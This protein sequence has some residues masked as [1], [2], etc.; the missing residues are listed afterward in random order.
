MVKAKT[1]LDLLR[2]QLV[3]AQNDLISYSK[4]QG[5]SPVI[6]ANIQHKRAQVAALEA[7][8]KALEEQE[9]KE[10]GVQTSMQI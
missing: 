2:E 9:A 8:I 4:F 7:E 5:Q 6:D 3:G 10:Y 1:K